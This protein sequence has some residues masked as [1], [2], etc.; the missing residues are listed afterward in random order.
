MTRYSFVREKING[1][2]ESKIKGTGSA[3]QVSNRT[4]LQTKTTR[5]LVHLKVD[6]IVCTFPIFN[7][8]T[9][10]MLSIFP[11]CIQSDDN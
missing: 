4:S 3:P 5:S 2:V 10:V 9:Y 8:C 6:T 1:E 11:I 7:K